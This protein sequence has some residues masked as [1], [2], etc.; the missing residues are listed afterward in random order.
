MNNEKL[1]FSKRNHWVKSEKVSGL[2]FIGNTSSFIRVN[3]EQ[4]R[5]LKNKEYEKIDKE[6]YENLENIGAFVSSDESV[7]E[8]YKL[9]SVKN[10][11]YWLMEYW[12]NFAD[13]CN[14]NC[15]YCFQ[16]QE[17]QNKIITKEIIDK[18]I[19][20]LSFY[21]DLKELRINLAGGEPLLCPELIVYFYKQL[22]NL[23]NVKLDVG[24]ITNGYLLT[25]ENISLLD[26]INISY[27]ITIDGLETSH[28]KRRSHKSKNDSFETIMKNL[29]YFYQTHK[30]KNIDFHIRTNVD[31][32]NAEDVPLLYNL[33][34]EKY[35]NY[36]G[37]FINPVENYSKDDSNSN[38]FTNEE[39]ANYLIQLY[40][41]HH[42]FL[43][44][45]YFPV[46]RTAGGYCPADRNYSFV[47]T[48]NGDLLKCP[49]DV[50][51]KERI[52]RNI[53]SPN[54]Y[55]NYKPEYDYLLSNSIFNNKKCTEC[56]LLFQC[57]GGCPHKRL[58]GLKNCPPA[59]FQLDK[60][61]EI[62]YL[63]NKSPKI[64]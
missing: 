45:S 17:K 35:G 1:V 46:Y 44:Q 14:F 41:K 43:P 58:E 32:E 30:D 16:G 36:F 64:K 40:E 39:F 57:M 3:E 31:K 42:I 56:N 18:F 54:G 48:S 61:L 9:F 19:R 27:Q 29:D 28:N 21:K 47:L 15:S 33:I 52:I 55:Y 49:C 11:N 60:F 6:L 23:K 10:N 26:Q 22:E 13:C 4:E 7:L 37:Y 62:Y 5:L 53:N 63:E 59:F 25:K 24:L 51:K 8:K 12:I 50:G 38:L 34:K 20:N 2:L